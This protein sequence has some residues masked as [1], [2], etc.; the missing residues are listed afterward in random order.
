MATRLGR[1]PPR[2]QATGDGTVKMI[3]IDLRCGVNK[4]EGYVGIDFGLH[5]DVR[6]DLR[7]GL[8]LASNSVTVLRA[9]DFLEHMPD[10]IF[11][12]N[13]CWRVL[14]GGW[15]TLTLLRVEVPRFPHID[16]VKDPTH[17]KFF[18]PETFT[19]YLCGPDRLAEEYGMKLWDILEMTCEDHRI[20]ATLRPRGKP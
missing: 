2:G 20:W 16:S 9:K 15:Q 18:T 13:E 3:K 17:V 8:P 14:A 12:M 1:R 19:E 7:Q 5:A 10:T 11:I 6:A 4:P